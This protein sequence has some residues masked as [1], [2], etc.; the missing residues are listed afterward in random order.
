ME[1][2]ANTIFLRSI[3]NLPG[4]SFQPNMFLK[5]LPLLWRLQYNIKNIVKSI[6]TGLITKAKCNL[7]II[8]NPMMR[9][10][11]NFHNTLETV[12]IFKRTVKIT[13][14]WTP[15]NKNRIFHVYFGQTYSDFSQNIHSA[16]KV[17]YPPWL[18]RA[19]GSIIDA[20]SLLIPLFMG[21]V[22]LKRSQ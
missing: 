17:N 20:Q 19:T 14:T 3:K 18:I 8:P 4:V 11:S 1:S 5:I 13:L 21:I 15:S 9:T 16:I 10:R 22:A 7:F 12:A 2:L 6:N